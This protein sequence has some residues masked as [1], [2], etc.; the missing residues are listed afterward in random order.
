[1]LPVC[2]ARPG[3][4]PP[5]W[6][7][8]ADPA[9]PQTQAIP[10]VPGRKIHPWLR[11]AIRVGVSVGF[12]AILIWRIPDFSTHDL[13]PTWTASV[14][15]W[16]AASVGILLVAFALQTLRWIQVLRPLGVRA[17]FLRVFG[18]F[19][20]GQ[21]VSNVLPTAFAGDVVRISRLGR[22]TGDRAVAFASVAIERLTGWLVLPLISLV[23]IAAAERY[24]HLGRA[25]TTAISVDVVT[26]VALAAIL[27]AAGHPR[28]S[29]AARTATGWRR[30]LGSVHL[31][32]DSI[33]RSPAAV[34]GI[35]LVGTAFQV[36]QCLSVW[37][38][39]R[40]L[41]VSP[42][43]VAATFAFFPP[44]AIGQNLPVGFGGL[45]VREGGFV[46]FFGALGV[47]DA[48]AISLG[49]VTYLVT[50]AAS[51]LGAPAF[52]LGGWRSELRMAEAGTPLDPAA[53]LPDSTAPTA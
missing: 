45:G 21:F 16:L 34:G 18:E 32:L 1:M 43:T 36:T 29:D 28:F 38:A 53:A 30:W 46:L 5:Q 14:G 52:A 44:T 25:T 8:D 37:A 11:L 42:V 19:L 50:V 17:P 6:R 23:T 20:A 3:P 40:A 31:G 26:L 22:D 49:V 35:V 15:W 51:A 47:S 4:R 48:R 27:G 9:T 33:R 39:A 12:L 41:Q 7:I 24:R 2:V 10:P 13:F